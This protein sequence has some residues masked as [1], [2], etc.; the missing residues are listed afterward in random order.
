MKLSSFLFSTLLTVAGTF[1]AVAFCVMSITTTVHAQPRQ[2]L[3]TFVDADK[4]HDKQLDLQ[5]AKLAFP[6][7]EFKDANMDGLVSTLEAEA[8]LP[9]LSY[10]RDKHEDDGQIIGAEEY[11]S[12]SQQYALSA[13]TLRDGKLAPP[14]E[15]KDGEVKNDAQTDN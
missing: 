12:L 9:G 10:D 3:L 5:E 13:Q 1:S 6:L 8:A 7:V 4:D 2:V 11:E 14:L 15:S